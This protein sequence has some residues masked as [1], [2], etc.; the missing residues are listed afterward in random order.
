MFKKATLIKPEKSNRIGEKI[1]RIRVKI[2]SKKRTL[3]GHRTRRFERFQ[4]FSLDARLILDIKHTLLDRFLACM[5][6]ASIT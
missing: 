1:K 6:P 3:Q 5:K 4:T 2:L